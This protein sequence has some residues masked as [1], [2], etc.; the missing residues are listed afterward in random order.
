GY[1]IYRSE[2]GGGGT[3]RLVGQVAGSNTSFV[4][5]GGALGIVLDESSVKRRARFDASLV[6][7]P[8]T[9]VKSKGSRIEVSFGGQLIA[10]GDADQPIIFT[11]TR[12]DRY[13]ASGTF[14]TN[15]D[16]GVPDA[17]PVARG[18]WSGI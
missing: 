2:L 4:D 7:D 8:A 12:D 18:D 5:E 9:I 15:N 11:S 10:E 17:A 14:D 16:E 6:I 1:R 13:G 3:Y